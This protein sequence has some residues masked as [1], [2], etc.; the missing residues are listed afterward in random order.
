MHALQMICKIKYLLSSLSRLIESKPFE[1]VIG[2]KKRSFSV[3]AEAIAV[4]S[5]ALNSLINGRMLEGQKRSATLEDVDQGTFIRF[6]QFA[7]TGDYAVPVFETKEEATTTSEVEVER[8]RYPNPSPDT[9]DQPIEISPAEA[10]P[11]PVAWGYSPSK[12]SKMAKKPFR[13]VRLRQSFENSKHPL[14]AS[15]EQLSRECTPRPNNSPA[16]DY[17][18]VFLGHASLYVFAEKYGVDSLKALTLHKIHKTLLTFTLY[19][20]RI[21]DIVELVS[22]AY[23]PENTPEHE[24]RI[25]ELRALVTHY[26]ASEI[27]TIGKSEL[28]LSLLEE[29]GSFVRDFWMKVKERFM[30]AN[31]GIT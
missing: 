13:E 26:V 31:W 21:G 23:S 19:H 27:D 8:E 30:W 17:T 11:E 14:P 15:Q 1:F 2:R 4:Q 22:Y 18:T 7:Y 12:V 16:E 25:D 3:H 9:L 5:N 10:E 6:C 29:G 28:F 24:G 20:T